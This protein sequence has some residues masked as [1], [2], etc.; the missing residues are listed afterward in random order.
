MSEASQYHGQGFSPETGH[1]TQ[2]ASVFERSLPAPSS[3]ESPPLRRQSHR[4]PSLFVSARCPLA[5]PPCVSGVV[6]LPWPLVA[7]RVLAALHPRC[8]Q[9]SYLFHDRH[10]LACAMDMHHEIPNSPTSAPR[11]SNQERREEKLKLAL[12]SLTEHG[13]SFQDFVVGVLRCQ[14]ASVRLTTTKWLSRHASSD[15]ERY[16]PTLMMAEITEAVRTRGQPT[17]IA[18]YNTKMVDL[19]APALESEQTAAASNSWLHIP[20]ILKTKDGDMDDATLAEDFAVLK[21]HYLKTMPLSTRL[22][23]SLHQP[24]LP[25]S[26][27]DAP[28]SPD[29]ADRAT[30]GE[31]GAKLE[32][33]DLVS[34]GGVRCNRKANR[35]Q[36]TMGVFFALLRVPTLAHRV[37]N[38]FGFAVSARTA[39]RAMKAV[40]L[41]A[42]RKG[43]ELLQASPNRTVFL[44]DNLNVYIRHSVQRITNSNTSAALTSRTL[45]DLP[46]DVEP[47]SR[48]DLASLTRLDR[49]SA[50]VALLLQDNTNAD[51]RGAGF[52]ERAAAIH[53]A[54]A[55][56]PLLKIA[57]QHRH[58]LV[59]SLHRR[60][61]QHDVDRLSTH[62]TAVVPLKLLNVNEGTVDGTKRVLAT[63]AAELRLY[64]SSSSTLL[65]AGDLLTVMNVHAA[66]YA[67]RW[68]ET[69]TDQLQ[70]I[71]PVAG[72][73]HLLLNWVYMM[74]KTYASAE[75]SSSLERLR[76]ALGR[77]K[78]AL[79]M[80]LPQFEEGWHLLMHVWQGRLLA[81]MEHDLQ[82]AGQRFEKWAPNTDE[83]FKAVAVLYKN[84]FSPSALAAARDHNDN[85]RAT[86]ILFLRDGVLV[87]EYENAIRAGDVRRMA[88]AE[89]SLCLAFYGAG[90]TKYGALLLDRALIDKELPKLAR[91]L[92]AAQLVNIH[93]RDNGWQ[94]ADHFQELLN[95]RLKM[96]DVSHSAEQAISRFEDRVSAFVAVGQTLVSQL[97][98]GLDLCAAP[99]RK[100][101][102]VLV[103]DVRLLA[104]DAHKHGLN[105]SQARSRRT[106]SNMSLSDPTI[107]LT[108]A[109]QAQGVWQE[110]R[111]EITAVD[112][113]E[114]GY[115]KLLASGLQRFK[116]R[117]Q[118]LRERDADVWQ[119]A[120]GRDSP[121]PPAA[122]ENAP[123]PQGP[124]AGQSVDVDD[125]DV[126][127]AEGQLVDAAVERCEAN[128]EESSVSGED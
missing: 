91:S 15:S 87:L 77:G 62:K 41:R 94:G 27:E 26:D 119:L 76:Q 75:R 28:S 67:A 101:R 86:S 48:Q 64:D 63:M 95:R 72:P 47:V 40:S 88:E 97:Q 3:D 108:A 33:K 98:R 71:Y 55:L 9:T 6:V 59:S 14:D 102:V 113:L 57:P 79:N 61:R 54:A 20:A 92:R 4:A 100:K 122:D 12:R 24:R 49:A 29:S 1:F 126:S 17:H 23:S 128:S 90:Q 52:F 35:F 99:P 7:F 111:G 103:E 66:Q 107:K 22:L 11:A 60:Q 19:L 123:A 45:F 112:L 50:S 125:E 31:I 39:S 116:E 118:T 124:D 51:G 127:W 110:D 114:A 74:F 104:D 115:L 73:W 42:A 120:T 106:G 34:C 109:Q 117:K 2:G 83:F 93:G 85:E 10:L 65:V 58:T 81:A 96:F 18:A 89:R 69:E 8:S 68:E 21:A 38:H 82:L 46:P 5:L 37:L 30:D 44:F 121:E 70:H 80:D 105:A 43:R 13:L 25:Q 78:T 16:G 84:H 56:L 32:S 53:I 36:M